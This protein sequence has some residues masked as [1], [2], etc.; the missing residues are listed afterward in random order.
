M[1]KLEV[2]DMKELS[3][4][5][6]LF[7]PCVGKRIDALSAEEERVLSTWEEGSICASRKPKGK[8]KVDP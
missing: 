8:V 2:L 1:L 6:S 3:L 4:E 7:E 5:V